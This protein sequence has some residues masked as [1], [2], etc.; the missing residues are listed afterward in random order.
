MLL[1]KV[2]RGWSDDGSFPDHNLAV[3]L[4]GWATVL[5]VLRVLWVLRVLVLGVLEV[6]PLHGCSFRL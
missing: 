5:K 1:A 3:L 4:V 6:L 2:P